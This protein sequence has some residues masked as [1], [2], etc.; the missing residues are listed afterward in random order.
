[1]QTEIY[2]PQ[3]V[4]KYSISSDRALVEWLTIIED[5]SRAL[6]SNI[7]QLIQTNR[8]IFYTLCILLNSMIIKF[9]E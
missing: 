1:M 3:Y 4:C 8:Y 6:S 5:G 9:T 2:V 7:L